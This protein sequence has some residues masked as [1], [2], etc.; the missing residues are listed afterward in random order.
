MKR[1]RLDTVRAVLAGPTRPVADK[2]P[3]FM[4]RTYSSAGAVYTLRKGKHHPAAAMT[5]AKQVFRLKRRSCATI[6]Q[7]RAGKA[8]H[9][10]PP[11]TLD[12]FYITKLQTY[13]IDTCI[14]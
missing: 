13:T 14:C 8:A 5:Q 10:Y 7:E 3:G 11:R 9:Q 1:A 6:P 4:R 12:R 2:Q